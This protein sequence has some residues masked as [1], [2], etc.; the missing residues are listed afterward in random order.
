V[1]E[2]NAN[3]Q[4]VLKIN[5]DDRLA[6]KVLQWLSAPDSSKNYNEA[7]KKHQKDTCSWFLD[8]TWFSD[9]QDKADILWIKGTAGCGKTILCSSIIERIANLH[10]DDGK[11]AYAY[12]F[13]DG[14]DS[15]KDLQLHD[16]LIRSLIMQFSTRCGGG[17][18]PATLVDL[19][20]YG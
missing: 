16:K 4:R 2:I 5:K 15:Q 1:K 20:G 11:N 10:H 13:F 12:F 17:G 7:R 14:R 6:E 8:G 3:L 19:Y 18:I 9:L